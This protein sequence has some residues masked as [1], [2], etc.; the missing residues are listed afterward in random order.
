MKLPIFLSVALISTLFLDAT[1]SLE[2]AINERDYKKAISLQK[3][4]I[5]SV[6]LQEKGALSYEL[7]L[8][9]LKDQDQ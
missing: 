3:E 9:Y 1:S 2:V 7:A 4:L 8:L 5:A 6:N